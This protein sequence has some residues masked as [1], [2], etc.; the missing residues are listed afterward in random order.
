M[1]LSNPGTEL[2]CTSFADIAVNLSACE[3]RAA[4][5]VKPPQRK[6]GAPGCLAAESADV[7]RLDYSRGRRYRAARAAAGAQGA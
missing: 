1:K 5:F 7:H 3:R 2:D 4:S 6:K